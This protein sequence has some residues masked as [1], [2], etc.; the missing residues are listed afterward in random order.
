MSRKS[1]KSTIVLDLDHTL[2]HSTS[3]R[4]EITDYSFF[5][6]DGNKGF[7]Y[8]GK[9]RPGTQA[10]L[11]VLKDKF[12][13]IIVWSA[14]TKEYV[15]LISLALFAPVGYVP[16]AI[17]SRKYCEQAK[18]NTDTCYKK[19]LKKIFAEYDADPFRTILVDDSSISML[20]NS[21][22]NTVLIPAFYHD[23]K[24]NIL[25]EMTKWISKLE[26]EDY[27]IFRKPKFQ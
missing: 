25:L 5:V 19:P 15:D 11:S 26:G 21:N 14:G 22:E 8:Y 9:I 13:Q 2:V 12:E 7:E 16:T 27:T 1:P 23:K 18:I 6:H 17:L 3:K 20:E 4:R 24:D 10:F